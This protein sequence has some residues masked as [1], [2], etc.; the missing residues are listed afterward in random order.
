MLGY[1]HH[2]A[3][4]VGWGSEMGRAGGKASSVLMGSDKSLP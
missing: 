4:C 1:P 3:V 2:A